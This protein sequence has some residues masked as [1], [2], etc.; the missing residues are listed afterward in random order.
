MDLSDHLLVATYLIWS[1]LDPIYF[2]PEDGSGMFLRNVSIHVIL[3]GYHSQEDRNTWTVTRLQAWILTEI[4]FIQQ[5][6]IGLYVTDAK[7]NH[8]SSNSFEDVT[9][10]SGGGADKTQ[11]RYF[12]SIFSVCSLVVAKNDVRW[13]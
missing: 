4:K 10:V 7:F 8:N 6:L 11:R 1:P 3:H 5:L 2:N 12:M 9:C 13:Q